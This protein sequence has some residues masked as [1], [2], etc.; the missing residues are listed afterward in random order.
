MNIG[1]IGLGIMGNPMAV[2]LCKAGYSLWV[3][4]R[5]PE[6]MQALTDIGATACPSPKAVAEQTEIIFTMVSDT[7]DVEE[8]ILGENG[9]LSGASSGNLVIDMSSIAASSTRNIAAAL[10]EKGVEMLDAPVSGG[11]KGAI[12]GNLSIMVGGKAAQFEPLL[13]LVRH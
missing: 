8:V 12:A 4:A 2:N 11:D 7:P 5:R 3:H 9:V 6:M 10:A 13:L 1:F